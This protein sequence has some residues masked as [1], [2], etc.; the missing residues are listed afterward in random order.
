MA[1]LDTGLDLNHSSLED[2]KDRIQGKNQKNF[3]NDGQKNVQDHDGHGT[4]V[5]GLF[6]KLAECTELFIARISSDRRVEKDEVVAEVVRTVC[7]PVNSANDVQAI[8]W[9]IGQ[10]VDIINMSF[11]YEDRI[12]DID[13]AI[14]EAVRQDII[15]FAAAANHG[16]RNK[17]AWPA[18]SSHVICVHASDGFGSSSTFTPASSDGMLNFAILGEAVESFWISD[19]GK[20]D[21]HDTMKRKSGTSFA[22]PILAAYCAT[23][24]YYIR[25]KFSPERQRLITYARTKEGM[26]AILGHPGLVDRRKSPGYSVVIPWGLLKATS[27]HDQLVERLEGK[28]RH[29]G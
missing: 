14:K 23:I 1:I 6:L 29:T 7:F 28:G 15:I 26:V 22:A 16:A 5:A 8:R 27:L 10:R 19:S 3:V 12:D 13:D 25:L 9:A 4:H 18:K 20:Q 17:I 2:F 24:L 21:K 11:G